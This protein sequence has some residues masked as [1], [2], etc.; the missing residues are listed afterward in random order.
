M[1]YVKEHEVRPSIK[2]L[3][4]NNIIRRVI[5]EE[6][7]WSY[8]VEPNYVLIDSYV[9]VVSTIEVEEDPYYGV[10][11]VATVI[12]VGDDP[13]AVATDYKAEDPYLPLCIYKHVPAIDILEEVK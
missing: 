5:N 10:A 9:G 11:H 1:Q 3:L 12:G 2:D 13:Q 6:H 7:F 4:Y 8:S